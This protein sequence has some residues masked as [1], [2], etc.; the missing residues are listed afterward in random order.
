V[1]LGVCVK[2]MC[3]VNNMRWCVL[4]NM[5]ACMHGRVN[6]HISV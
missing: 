5:H 1:W 4:F 2:F 6:V 3:V